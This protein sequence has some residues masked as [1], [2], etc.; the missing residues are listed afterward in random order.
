MPIEHFSHV[1]IR[2]SDLARSVAFYRDQIG[3]EEVS[4]FTAKDSPSFR[5]HGI[6]GATM[7]ATFLR[8]PG[9]VIELQ[10][11]LD[12]QGAQLSA[13]VFPYGLRQLSF[14]AT[15]LGS[16]ISELEEAGTTVI[17][18][19]R[20]TLFEGAVDLVFAEDPDGTRIELMVLPGDPAELPE[21]S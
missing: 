9:T 20:H 5:L 7:N 16:V 11:L 12:D 15:D 18:D 1:A 8:R 6:E 21:V 14:R 10:E 3:Y 17:H 4:S 19:S 2:V 13:E